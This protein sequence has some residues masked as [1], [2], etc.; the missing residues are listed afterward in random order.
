MYDL[1]LCITYSLSTS[2]LLARL[3][4]KSNDTYSNK[5]LPIEFGIVVTQTCHCVIAT[6]IAKSL[7]I[8]YTNYVFICYELPASIIRK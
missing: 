7:H 1:A 3:I 4:I 6:S 8:Y 5:R 2:C